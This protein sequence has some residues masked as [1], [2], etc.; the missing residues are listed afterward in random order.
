[1]A[2]NSIPDEIRTPIRDA[3]FWARIDIRGPDDCWLWNV[4]T[5]LTQGGYGSAF[6]GPLRTVAHRIA[7]MLCEG[8]LPEGAKVLHRCDIRRC[9]NTAHLFVGS[10]KDNSED[11]VA[12]GRG[13]AP[14][15][16]LFGE[17]NKNAKLSDLDVQRI[18]ALGL[19]LP[20]RTIARIYGVSKSQVG[21][22]VRGDSRSLPTELATL[23]KKATRSKFRDTES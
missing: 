2:V 8:P 1:M 12:K 15:A 11:M 3:A 5:Q 13:R 4:D 6:Y 23:V 7:W 19:L 22:I 14:N 21:N 18:K 10:S 9:C 17:E 16:N 20:Q